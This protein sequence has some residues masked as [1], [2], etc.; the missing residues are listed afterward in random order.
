MKTTIEE[1]KL[2]IETRNH[3]IHLESDGVSL[4]EMWNGIVV[5]ANDHNARQ[6]ELSI[7]FDRYAILR[8][9]NGQYITEIL[10]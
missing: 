9:D 5:A 10:F 6:I 1:G 3:R 2:T 8:D 4:K 7:R